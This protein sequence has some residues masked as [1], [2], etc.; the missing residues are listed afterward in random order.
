MSCEEAALFSVS[1]EEVGSKLHNLILG[2]LLTISGRRHIEALRC[3]LHCNETMK[4]VI[5]HL[6]TS[7]A[8]VV[9]ATMADEVITVKVSVC[10]VKC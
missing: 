9:Q 6:L 7:L 5:V 2:L 10:H 3:K 1:P 8:F 4:C